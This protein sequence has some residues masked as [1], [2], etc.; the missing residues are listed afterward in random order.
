M[1]KKESPSNQSG[2]QKGKKD[3]KKDGTLISFY[4]VKAPLAEDS[5]RI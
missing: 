5:F 2:K 3:G 1:S 4:H